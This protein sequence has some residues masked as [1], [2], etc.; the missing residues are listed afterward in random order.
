[1]HY[2]C[3]STI[4][5]M[6]ELHKTCKDERVYTEKALKIRPENHNGMDK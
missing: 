4:C 2:C 1:M 3:D 6:N 5:L